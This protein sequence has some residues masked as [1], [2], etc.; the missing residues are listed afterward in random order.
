MLLPVIIQSVQAQKKVHIYIITSS[1]ITIVSFLV[2]ISVL[3]PA[4][5]ISS[6]QFAKMADII[7]A[8][9]ER[10]GKRLRSSDPDLQV[11][12]GSGEEKTVQW[13][14]SQTLASKSKYI[15]TMLA[16]PMRERED[17]VISFPDIKPD[18]WAKMMKFLDDPIASREMNAND[19][20]EVVVYSMTNTSLLMVG[21]FVY[22]L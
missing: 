19:A 9:D 21:G 14:H 3:R 1:P 6:K 8:A 13:Y 5:A 16:V 22:I 20:V 15:D 12:L 18:V 11:I 7:A 17:R 10:D 2:S 4:I